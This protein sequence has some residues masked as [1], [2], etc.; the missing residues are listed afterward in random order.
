MSDGKII[1]ENGENIM[2]VTHE[3]CVLD[4]EGNPI[5]EIIGDVSLLRTKS[6]N[7]VDAINEVFNDITK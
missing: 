5:T 4:D 1:R 2:P 6:K 7:L 3:T